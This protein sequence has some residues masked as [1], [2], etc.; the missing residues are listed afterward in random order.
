MHAVIALHHIFR[1]YKHPSILPCLHIYSGNA[2]AR[3]SN[4]SIVWAYSSKS[5]RLWA[6]SSAAKDVLICIE[7]PA[8]R[9]LVCAGRTESVLLV[10]SCI[11]KIST[12]RAKCAFVRGN[13][14][15]S[16]MFDNFFCFGE[17]RARETV[18]RTVVYI[19]A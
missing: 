11:R 4:T 17:V 2:W 7:S 9:S 6:V 5:R 15:C 3:R 12:P 14:E 16:L 8:R 19:F 18:E 13:G 10:E 1:I